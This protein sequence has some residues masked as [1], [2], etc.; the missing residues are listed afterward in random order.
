MCGTVYAWRSVV[1]MLE[2][3]ERDRERERGFNRFKSLGVKQDQPCAEINV[4]LIDCNMGTG[5]NRSSVLKHII[6]D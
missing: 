3:T 6:F 4:C 2:V 1:C 5:T